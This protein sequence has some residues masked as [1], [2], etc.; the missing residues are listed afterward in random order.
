MPMVALASAVAA[1]PGPVSPHEAGGSGPPVQRGG[2]HD[3]L[4]VPTLVIQDHLPVHPGLHCGGDFLRA[5][6]GIAR[7]HQAAGVLGDLQQ[8]G[9]AQRLVVEDRGR[10]GLGLP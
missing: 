4:E 2:A 10:P 3:E 9:D 5:A 1:L 6:P 7:R 8:A